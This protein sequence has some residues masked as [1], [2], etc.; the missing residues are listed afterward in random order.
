MTDS[1]IDDLLD[2]RLDDEAPEGVCPRCGEDLDEG[3]YPGTYA[4]CG[5]CYGGRSEPC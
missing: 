5:D 1:T 2:A 3:Y 4:T